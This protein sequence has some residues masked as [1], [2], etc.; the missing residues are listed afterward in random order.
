M[1]CGGTGALLLA[2]L[3]PARLEIG[4]S[5]HLHAML[6][7]MSLHGLP[8]MAAGFVLDALI[9]SCMA[10]GARRVLHGRR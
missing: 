5:T 9:L 2:V 10:L 6:T 7:S 1:T 8:G 4:E 3:S